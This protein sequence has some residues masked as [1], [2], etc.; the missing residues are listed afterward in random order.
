M[1]KTRN[2]L[3]NRALSNLGALPVGQTA[4]TEEYSSVDALV[5]PTLES[6]QARDIFHVPDV[7]AI[8]DAAFISLGHCLAW[9]CAS[10]FGLHS[11]AALAAMNA[12]AEVHL[13]AIQSEVPTYKI[14]EIMAY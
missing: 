1:T 2:D 10:E 4:S 14:M 8:D 12:Q 9:N 7:S 6:L 13:K 11:D 5:D 3:V